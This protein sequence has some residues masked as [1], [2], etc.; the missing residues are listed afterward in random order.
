[1][2]Q[3]RDEFEIDTTKLDEKFSVFYRT[4]SYMPM[5]RFLALNKDRTPRQLRKPVPRSKSAALEELIG[6]VNGTKEVEPVITDSRQLKQLADVIDNRPAREYLRTTRDLAAAWQLT[7]GQ[8]N[9]L[10]SNL[11]RASICLDEALRDAYRYKQD[12]KV[13]ELVRRCAQSMIE[14]LRHHPDIKLDIEETK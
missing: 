10:I 13:K 8:E 6:Y 2:R 9:R 7:G 12:P 14:I 3:A 4:L 5:T 11:Q 1:M